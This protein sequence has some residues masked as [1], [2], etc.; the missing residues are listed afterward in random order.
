MEIGTMIRTR[1]T[2][3]G[4]TQEQV[5]AA[6]GVTATA[7]SKWE[8]DVS[9]PEIT[10]LP[11]LARLLGT[12]L[13]GLLA[14]QQEM[15]REEVARFLE[16]LHQA[17]EASGLDAAVAQAREQVKQFPRCA[18]LALNTALVL[19]GLAALSSQP[20]AEAD[21]QWVQSLYRQAA[22]NEDGAVAA[23][24]GAMLFHQAL[25]AG[26]LAQAETWLEGLPPQPLYDRASMTARLALARKNWD[27]AGAQWEH[28]LLQQV[29]QA[30]STL[31]SLMDLA[32]QEGQKKAIAPMAEAACALTEVFGL[33]PYGTW[34]VRLQQALLT[35]DAEGALTALEGLLDALDRPWVPGP[36]FRRLGGKET[37]FLTAQLRP[38]I[39]WELT[40]PDNSTYD[41]LRNSPRF[42]ALVE[43]AKG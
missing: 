6:L 16:Q 42:R 7:V 5:A 10:L 11:A 31:L 14:F 38:A 19:E 3:Q 1:R 9:L 2:A 32:A 35:E 43:K 37:A 34:S 39:L 36:L 24:A 33:W 4:L 15:T 21:A 29:S 17:A 20:L 12:D 23:Q 13:N 8:R 41:L 25:E 28:N 22:E 40:D 18:L 27:Q 26:D 30:Q